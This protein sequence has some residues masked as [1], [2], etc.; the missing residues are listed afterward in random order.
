MAKHVQLARCYFNDK[1]IADVLSNPRFGERSLLRLAQSIGIV[2]NSSEPKSALV[3]YLSRVPLDWKQLQVVAKALETPEREERRGV[4][5]LE[6]DLSSEQIEQA[7]ERVRTS[8]AGNREDFKVEKLDGRLVLKGRYIEIDHSRTK[9]LQREEKEYSV[10][11]D[12]TSAK[13]NIQFTHSPKAREFVAALVQQL[14]PEPESEIEAPIDLGAIKDPALRTDFFLKLRRLM[15]G[16]RQIDV[17]DLRVDHRFEQAADGEDAED[18]AESADEQVQEEMR[19]MVRSAAFQGHGLL[20]SEL[21]QKLRELGYFVY[22]MQ[23]SS[24]EADSSGRLMEF[25]VGFE[26]PVRASSFHY[27]LKRVVPNEHDRNSGL[28]QLEVTARERDRVRRML[29]DAAYKALEE[30][31]ESLGRNET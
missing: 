26:D 28:T 9:A 10:E 2:F 12:P 19:G 5:R 16:F 29:V 11:I 21:Y 20:T 6:Q 17:L 1:D 25:E 4:T 24:V 8:R 22:R 3:S 15:P 14:K 13:P 7:I 23:W 30:I 31:K 18:E 27:D